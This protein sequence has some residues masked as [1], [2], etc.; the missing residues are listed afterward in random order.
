MDSTGPVKLDMRP[1]SIHV[2]M[3]IGNY[4]PAKQTMAGS[5]VRSKG[6]INMPKRLASEMARRSFDALLESL[7]GEVELIPDEAR[8]LLAGCEM[9]ALQLERLWQLAQAFL[10]RGMEHKRL[11]WLFKEFTEV[12][13]LGV[14]G[15]A[16]AR[17]KIKTLRLAPDERAESLASMDRMAGRATQMRS[18]LLALL[19]W[20]E[21]GPL[22][23]VSLPPNRG[24]PGCGYISLEDLKA[25]FGA[26]DMD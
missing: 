21:K 16:A 14:R 5:S 11:V 7:E 8:E 26:K 10:D 18:E 12:I 1:I 3:H 23:V 19:R 22:E 15:F 25:R 6:G 9:G 24:D 20:L 2:K 4:H 13:D 17:E